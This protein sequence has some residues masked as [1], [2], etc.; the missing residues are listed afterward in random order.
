MCWR[1]QEELGILEAREFA[2]KEDKAM[3][4]PGLTGFA[5][6]LLCGSLAQGAL[7]VDAGDWSFARDSGVHR[8]TIGIDGT[9][10]VMGA[11]VVLEIGGAGTLPQLVNGEIVSGT[12]FASNN[13]GAPSNDFSDPECAYMDVSTQSGTVPVT[14]PA[15]LAFV[16]VNTNGASPGTYTL[17]LTATRFGDSDLQTNPTVGVTFIGGTFAVVPEPVFFGMMGVISGGLLL[18]RRTAEAE[19]A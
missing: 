15:S 13:T 6:V 16:D 1:R 14:G 8:I 19:L 12:I 9:G 4:K 3:T 7:T 2:K 18:R 17:A 10:Q 11:V 5:G